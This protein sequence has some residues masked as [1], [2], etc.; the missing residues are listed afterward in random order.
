MLYLDYTKRQYKFVSL[1]TG[2]EM[3]RMQGKGVVFCV[4]SV[5]DLLNIGEDGKSCKC[6]HKSANA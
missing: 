1:K 6:A 3:Q 4:S 5:S 2:E